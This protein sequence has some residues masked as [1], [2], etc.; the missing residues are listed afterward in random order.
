MVQRLVQQAKWNL[1]SRIVEPPPT[2]GDETQDWSE[3]RFSCEAGTY[4]DE[5]EGRS[6]AATPAA[7][8]GDEELEVKLVFRSGV[9]I[10]VGG[11]DPNRRSSFKRN[12]SNPLW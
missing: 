8:V 5:D 12:Y 2:M 10:Q 1:P 4:R 6:A 11:H 3:Q 7:A 9:H